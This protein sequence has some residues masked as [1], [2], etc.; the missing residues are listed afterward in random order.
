MV[1]W[2]TPFSPAN[3]DKEILACKVILLSA[4]NVFHHS[5]DR[6]EQH[7]ISIPV[8]EIVEGRNGELLKPLIQ[9]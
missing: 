6:A 9:N 8:D 5:S 2:D 7:F 1:F 3:Q 4:A